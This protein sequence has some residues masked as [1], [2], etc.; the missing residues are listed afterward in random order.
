MYTVT[1]KVWKR[2]QLTASCGTS[3]SAA[4]SCSLDI[5]LITVPF[6]LVN[7]QLSSI[8]ILPQREA[9]SRVLPFLTFFYDATPFFYFTFGSSVNG[10]LQSE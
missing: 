4:T 9:A 7:P 5:F 6:N 1:L 8:K 10:G 3:L 2:K